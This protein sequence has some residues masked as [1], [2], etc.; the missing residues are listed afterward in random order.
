MQEPVPTDTNP[1]LPSQ[2]A[3]IGNVESQGSASE[4]AYLADESSVDGFAWLRRNP[5]LGCL[6][7]HIWLKAGP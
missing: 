6:L 3:Y 1:V 4:G 5:V 7:R 2:L